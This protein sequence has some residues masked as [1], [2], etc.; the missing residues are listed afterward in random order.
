MSRMETVF[1][2]GGW[3][4]VHDPYDTYKHNV[5]ILYQGVKVGW[6]Y[7]NWDNSENWK[8][9]QGDKQIQSRIDTF[10]LIYER[11]LEEQRK[12]SREDWER[13]MR[14]YNKKE[15]TEAYAALGIDKD[16]T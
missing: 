13:E 11:H 14:E 10:R 7:Q 2:Y 1:K 16:N 5:E 15:L 12:K 4:I 6:V 9:I 3:E 8:A